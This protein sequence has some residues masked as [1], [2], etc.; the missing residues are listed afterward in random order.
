[1]TI[2]EV[3]DRIEEPTAAIKQAAFQLPEIASITPASIIG[4]RGS[5]HRP[6]DFHLLFI[7]LL[8]YCALAIDDGR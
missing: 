4:K 7:Y 1:M 5:Q 6:D 3:A 8:I 2:S